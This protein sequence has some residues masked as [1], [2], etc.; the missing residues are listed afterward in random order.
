MLETD[1]P[2]ETLSV[3]DAVAIVVGVVVG[4]GIFKTPS[5]VAASAES[6][7]MVLLFW[8]VGGLA[9][10]VGA[11]CYAELMSVLFPFP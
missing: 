4:V 8:L 9:S 7:G 1:K 3:V 6:E 10:L 2:E 5:I 11:L